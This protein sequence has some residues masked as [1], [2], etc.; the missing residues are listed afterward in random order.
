MELIDAH[1]ADLQIQ[2]DY[3]SRALEAREAYI[4]FQLIRGQP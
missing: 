3:V 2:T 4:Q 1:R